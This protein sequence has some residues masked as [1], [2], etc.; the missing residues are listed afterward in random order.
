MLGMP[1][2]QS[3]QP[4]EGKIVK[5]KRKRPRSGHTI[6]F[7][8]QVERISIKEEFESNPLTEESE[9]TVFMDDR[10]EFIDPVTLSWEDAFPPEDPRL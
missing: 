2:Q 4:I 9:S 10:L 1:V 6:V 8:P 5:Q 3:R 7:A